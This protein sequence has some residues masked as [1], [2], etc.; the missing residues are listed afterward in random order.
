[1]FDQAPKGKRFFRDL[2]LACF[3]PRKVEDVVQDS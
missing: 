1:L 2:H 3:N